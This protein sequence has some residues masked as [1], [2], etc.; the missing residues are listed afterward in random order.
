[1]R[2]ESRD[3]RGSKGGRKRTPLVFVRKGTRSWRALEAYW[4]ARDEP[5][6]ML[7][8]YFV[9]SCTGRHFQRSVIDA[10]LHEAASYWMRKSGA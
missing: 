3:K 1:M 8:I 2:T 10:A 9:D 5:E 4:Q 6:Q 7:R